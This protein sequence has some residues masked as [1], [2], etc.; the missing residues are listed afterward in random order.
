MVLKSWTLGN[1]LNVLV[2][3]DSYSKEVVIGCA[4][5]YGT[6]AAPPQ[7]IQLPHLLE[8]LVIFNGTKNMSGEEIRET[9]YSMHKD[10]NA[11]TFDD[12]TYYE[13][14]T[15]KKNY[16]A[17]LHILSEMVNYA[18]LLPLS[19]EVEKKRVRAEIVEESNDKL[20]LADKLY[21]YAACGLDGSKWVFREEPDSL[22]RINETDL[23]NVFV[24]FYVPNNMAVFMNSNIDLSEAIGS[25]EMHF[26]NVRPREIVNS[27]CEKM[28]DLKKWGMNSTKDDIVIRLAGVADC[29]S[30]IGFEMHGLSAIHGPK[31]LAEKRILFDILSDRFVSYSSLYKPPITYGPKLFADECK[32][33]CSF[34]VENVVEYVDFK[35]LKNRV[36]REM[37]DIA[38]GNISKEEFTKSKSYLKDAYSLTGGTGIPDE[39]HCESMAM[40][41]ML[42]RRTDY[43]EYVK[44]IKDISIRSVRNLAR[45]IDPHR[46]TS[47]LVVPENKRPTYSK[48]KR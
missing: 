36:I 18:S 1:N 17:A 25:I 40:Y 16:K 15:T 42:M 45:T 7:Q 41:S 14:T 33:I 38:A 29:I 28:T 23:Q 2:N 37:G 31:E 12:Y 47:V 10:V 43:D 19:I 6:N 22:A 8:H 44:S 39:S 4:V 13:I 35:S 48:S 20:K 34:S 32:D 9:I 5:N 3:K 30:V 24:N 27:S 26:G 46:F 21:S 11:Y